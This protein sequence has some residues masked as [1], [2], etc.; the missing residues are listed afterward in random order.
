M[1][2]EFLDLPDELLREIFLMTDERGMTSY[3][4]VSRRL[5]RVIS[6]Y[7][8]WMKKYKVKLIK[9]LLQHIEFLRSSPGKLPEQMNT[10]VMIYRQ[11]SHPVFRDYDRFLTTSINKYHE[12]SIQHPI[13][14]QRLMPYFQRLW[15][16]KYLHSS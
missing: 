6:H 7:E 13:M 5:N 2:T 11:A 15:R 9:R 12:L 4:S 1:S 8:R 14:R 10:S 16:M 3:L